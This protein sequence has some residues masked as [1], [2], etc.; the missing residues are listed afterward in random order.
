[1][2]DPSKFSKHLLCSLLSTAVVLLTI[3]AEAQLPTPASGVAVVR[4]AP[5]AR[6]LATWRVGDPTLR[7]GNES[8]TGPS[9]FVDVV[10]VFFLSDNRLL[11]ADGQSSEFR[12]FALPSGRH[13]GTFG[14]K[15]QGP[16]EISDLWTVWR[17]ATA[18][19]AEDAA[20]KASV[21]TL[22]GRYVRSIPRGVEDAARRVERRGMFNDSLSLASVV[23]EPLGLAANDQG[24][25]WVRLLAVTPSSSTLLARYPHRVV[26]RTPSGRLRS[27]IFAS[28]SVAS[29]VE[30][31]ACIGYPATYVIDCYTPQ[32]RHSLR[33]ERAGVQSQR[34]TA[35]NRE[36]FFASESAANPGPRGASYVAQ[37]RTATRFAETLPLFGEFVA[38]SNGD[39][40]VGPYTPVGPIPMKRPYPR[41]PTTWSVYGVDGR[42]KADVQLPTRFQLFAVGDNQVAGVLRDM[43]DVEQVIVLPLLK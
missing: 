43:D 40:W 21:F 15:G 28:Q 16:G 35:E 17:T 13:S 30:G 2:R 24:L 33:I 25:S 42:W 34:V 3:P 39:L 6:A 31:R 10:G 4:Y 36:D 23:E 27:A 7:I 26:T 11:V 8:E 19:V 38:A 41:K 1:M 18:V 29:V 14:A 12:V 22:N 5:G 37:L 32:G 20:G 9:A